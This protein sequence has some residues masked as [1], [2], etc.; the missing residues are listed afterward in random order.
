MAVVLKRHL[1][2]SICGLLRVR[3]DTLLSLCFSF[4]P[5]LLCRIAIELRG[6][7]AI[8]FLCILLGICLLPLVFAIRNVQ[9]A[10]ISATTLASQNMARGFIDKLPVYSPGHE[11]QQ[12]WVALLNRFI[13]HILFAV[14]LL[15][16]CPARKAIHCGMSTNLMTEWFELN[17]IHCF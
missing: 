1:W 5:F 2:H 7:V 17:S 16:D 11:T 8:D 3:D 10:N 6:A 13:E 12:F 15:A 9:H 14:E 4:L